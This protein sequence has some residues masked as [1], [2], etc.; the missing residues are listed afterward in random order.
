[1]QHNLYEIKVPLFPKKMLQLSWKHGGTSWH[2]LIDFIDASKFSDIKIVRTPRALNHVSSDPLTIRTAPSLE[3]KEITES[4]TMQILDHKSKRSSHQ[5][6]QK[7]DHE[8]KQCGFF[9]NVENIQ[10]SLYTTHTSSIC[11]HVNGPTLDTW[12]NTPPQDGR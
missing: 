6:H 10:H 2:I 9:W 11:V 12:P 3:S 1:M 7:S 8:Y 5:R 4:T